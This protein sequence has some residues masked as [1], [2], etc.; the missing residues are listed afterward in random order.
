[1]WPKCPGFK[2]GGLLKEPVF[3]QLS[4]EV[5]R[6]EAD[7]EKTVLYKSEMLKNASRVVWKACTL[8]CQEISDEASRQLEVTCYFKDEK[9]RSTIAGGF[10]TTHRELRT[11][12]E[13]FTLTNPLYKGG[14]KVCGQFDVI[15]RAELT[16]CSFLDYISFGTILNFAFAIDFSDAEGAQ[17]H[18]SQVNFTDNVEFAI[19][20]VGDT[21]ADYNRSNAYTAYGFGAR[22]PP[23]YRESHEFCLNLE[24]DPTCTGVDGVVTAF[25]NTYVQAQPCTTAQFSHVIYHVA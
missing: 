11:V 9:Y 6:T 22:I 23:L 14:L 16:I 5:V 25:R 15:K 20:S 8:S 1:S 7:G 21:F 2:K 24:T 12:Q 18:E 3:L 13:P 19:R 17:D 4:F 10:T